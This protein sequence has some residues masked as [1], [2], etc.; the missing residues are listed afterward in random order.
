M[1]MDMEMDIDIDDNYTE[2]EEANTES[3]FARCNKDKI[4][5]A[6]VEAV[7]ETKYVKNVGFLGNEALKTHRAAE[8]IDVEKYEMIVE[9]L[10]K[11]AISVEYFADNYYHILAL[12]RGLEIVNMYPK[13]RELLNLIID[14]KRIITCAARQSGKCFKNG[15]VNIRNKKTGEIREILI[16]DFYAIH[17]QQQE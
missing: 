4:I 17:Q 10:T 6:E 3:Y 14:E 5:D 13:Q 11:C 1:D 15:Y 8:I 2:E 16:D 12:D 9:E 7:Q